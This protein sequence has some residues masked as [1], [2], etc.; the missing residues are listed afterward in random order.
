M[1]ENAETDRQTTLKHG[2]S[3]GSP[4]GGSLG[5]AGAHQPPHPGGF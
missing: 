2:L 3:I 4:V 5:R 1:R